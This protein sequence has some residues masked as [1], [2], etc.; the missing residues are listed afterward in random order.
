MH[1]RIQRARQSA[2]S[3]EPGIARPRPSGGDPVSEGLLVMQRLAGNAAVAGILG[4]PTVQRFW[5]FDDDEEEDEDGYDKAEGEVDGGEEE[6]RFPEARVSGWVA[7]GQVGLAIQPEDP[8][9]KSDQS[10]ASRLLPWALLEAAE[11]PYEPI[12]RGIRSGGAGWH[13]YQDVWP[14]PPNPFS[15]GR[16][17]VARQ[18]MR[19][20]AGKPSPDIERIVN[21]QNGPDGGPSGGG[22][23]PAAPGAGG[24][25][26]GG[27]ASGA[28]PGAGPTTGGPGG[29]IPGLQPVG[30]GY[31]GGWPTPV[32]PGQQP[33]IPGLE[34]VP[35]GA[36]PGAPGAGGPGASRPMLRRG[37][38]GEA[39]RDL[40]SL[41][42]GHGATLDS[43]GIFGSLTKQAV[44]DFQA[45]SGLDVDGIVG[46]KT[47]DALGAT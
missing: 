28:G 25:A 14:T 13:R 3:R 30:S 19:H 27:G 43:D 37:S 22:P 17:V 47:W 15:D 7:P 21:G 1:D 29:E 36:A 33:S 4:M 32:T 18:A 39:V 38:T 46:P 26:A 45:R 40:Q 42:V 20:Y 44:L 11:L 35:G 6:P 16:D 5:P 9:R 10:L 31:A 23:G 12:P 24:P 34:P 8:D 41:L 2:G